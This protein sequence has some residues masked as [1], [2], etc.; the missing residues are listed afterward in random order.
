MA[1]ALQSPLTL[2]HR[3]MR[4]RV[5]MAP[6]TRARAGQPGDIP[7]ALNAR[8]YGQRASAGLIITEGTPIAPQ[9]K[10]Y[11]FTPGIFSDAQINGWKQ[12]TA[13]VH[14]HQ[15]LIAAQLWHVGRMAHHSVLPDGQ[16]PLAPSAIRAKAQ[17][18][19]FDEQGNPGMVDCSEPRAMT[20]EDMAEVKQQF[21]QAAENA[22]NAG[23]DFV[24]LHGANGY[25]LEQ[26]L[27]MATNRRDD[28]YGGSLENRARFVLEVVD[29]VIERIGA[30]HL[31]IRLS[32][33]CPPAV[34]D[35]DFSAEADVMTLYLAEQL[36]RRGIAFIHLAEWP[37]SDYPDGFR[38]ELRNTYKGAIIVAGNYDADRGEQIIEAGLADA[39]AY[40]RPFIANPDL[41]RRLFQR[42]TLSEPD[43]ATFYGGN[44]QGYT[45]YPALAAG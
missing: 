11:A 7:T 2:G 10:G 18:F 22:R 8:Y 25:L 16:A 5:A 39:V 36:D 41:P 24:E 6:M 32:P 35:M 31:G 12:V 33:W 20:L 21:A 34:N 30:H 29:S 43:P 13:A 9:A 42:L 15:G 3:E 4:N 38:R 19:A 23:F 14:Q 37:D 27:S 44:E 45:D 1:S 40:G 28:N 17:V 26:F